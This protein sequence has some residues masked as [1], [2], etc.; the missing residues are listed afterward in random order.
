MCSLRFFG[1]CALSTL[2]LVAPSF[3]AEAT[4][5]PSPQI[6][7]AE[8]QIAASILAAPEDQRDSATVLGYGADGELGTL[9]AG[10]GTMV[11]LADKPG[12]DRFH[13]ACYHRDLEPFMARGRALK[14]EGHD[15]DAVQATRLA[16][17]EA[18]TLS[19][20]DA[21]TA[22][23]NVSGPEGAF[24]AATGTLSDVRRVHVV[25]IPYATEETTGISAAPRTDGT[26][27]LMGAG[28]PWAHIMIIPPPPAPPEAEAE[29]SEE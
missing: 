9:R 12:D 2:M 18:G 7:P 13:V 19:I 3:A 25:Y 20:P 28:K 29:A 27:W 17:I 1:I 22:L 26:P 5:A 10:E 15:R 16:E 6:A 23:Y 4:G 24:D 21:P 8:H 14:A 11:C